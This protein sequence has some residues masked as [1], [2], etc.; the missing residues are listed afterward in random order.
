MAT[1]DSA[2]TSTEK[3]MGRTIYTPRWLLA[4]SNIALRV[5]NA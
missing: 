4:Q 1:G 2:T 5:M 3:Q